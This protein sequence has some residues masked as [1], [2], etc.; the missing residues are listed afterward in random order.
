M[1]QHLLSLFF[2][3][4]VSLSPHPA[5]AHPLNVLHAHHRHHT[6]KHRALRL[7]SLHRDSVQHPL[8]PPQTN[9]T[10]R[11]EIS[12]NLTLAFSPCSL[13]P[14]SPPPASIFHS[15]I[16]PLDDSPHESKS[17]LH[18]PSTSIFLLPMLTHSLLFKTVSSPPKHSLHTA[19]VSVTRQR[20]DQ[21]KDSDHQAGSGGHIECIVEHVGEGGEQQVIFRESDG[22]VDFWDKKGRWL[23]KG[24]RKGENSRN[25]SVKCVRVG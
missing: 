17:V 3:L 24:L 8:S 16:V 11:I 22:E 21:F 20:P 2:L 6:H 13:N 23:L 15:L 18:Y 12:A 19:R 14:S 10:T 1:H 9:T 25:A 5:I 7:P 4:V